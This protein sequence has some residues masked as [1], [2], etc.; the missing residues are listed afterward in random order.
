M[1]RIAEDLT[2]DKKTSGTTIASRTAPRLATNGALPNYLLRSFFAPTGHEDVWS[3]PLPEVCALF[4]IKIDVMRESAELKILG[5]QGETQ[6][7]E[8]VR[9]LEESIADGAIS[10]RSVLYDRSNARLMSGRNDRWLARIQE[11]LLGCVAT[12]VAEVAGPGEPITPT[13]SAHWQRFDKIAD[14]QAWLLRRA[15]D[16]AA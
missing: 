5:T 2:T 10:G 4:S 6:L 13:L 7:A 9:E 12:R 14:A 11:L 15:E 1:V 16:I 3:F 8:F